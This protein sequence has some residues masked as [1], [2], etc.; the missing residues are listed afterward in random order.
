MPIRSLSAA[1]MAVVLLWLSACAPE[2]PPTP[3]RLFVK[4]P[5]ERS[6]LVRFEDGKSQVGEEERSRLLAF[7]R[8][9]DLAGA[10]LVVLEGGRPDGK[11]RRDAVE[12]LLLAAGARA[13]SLLK[14]DGAAPADSLRVILHSDSYLAAD[15]L[16][17]AGLGPDAWVPGCANESNLI[18]M[19]ETPEDLLRGRDIGPG[20]AERGLR[21]MQRY[22][23]PESK[24]AP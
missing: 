5:L 17:E 22:R 16:G 6:L 15:C 4:Q 9:N 11:E 14:M 13:D 3:Q 24:E 7:A 18:H 12:K 2:R 21:A 23:Q 8:R 10:R 20:S 19:I 1:G